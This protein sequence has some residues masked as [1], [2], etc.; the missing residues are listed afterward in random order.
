MQVNGCAADRSQVQKEGGSILLWRG[1]NGTLSDKQEVA[2]CRVL[3]FLRGARDDWG[4]QRWLPH[5]K[6]LVG[7]CMLLV[8]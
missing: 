8:G 4:V 6:L 1:N 7:H 3:T 2:V 5:C